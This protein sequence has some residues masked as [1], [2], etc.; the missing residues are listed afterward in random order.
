MGVRPFSAG[1]GVMSSLTEIGRL[2]VL[3]AAMAVFIFA[4]QSAGGLTMR[5]E[6]P[7]QTGAATRAAPCAAETPAG[8]LSRTCPAPQG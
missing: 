4:A 5:R 7:I 8:W 1:V 6:I 2:L 3:P